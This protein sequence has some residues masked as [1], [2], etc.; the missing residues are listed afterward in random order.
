MKKEK[1]K[2]FLVKFTCTGH[3]EVYVE[4]VDAEAARRMVVDG[5][6]LPKNEKLIE[7][8]CDEIGRAELNE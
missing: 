6:A 2:S 4:A 7:W 5:E 3:G 1:K 8:S